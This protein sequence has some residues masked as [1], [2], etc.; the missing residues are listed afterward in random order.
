MDS[1]KPNDTV[2]E[3]SAADSSASADHPVGDVPANSNLK[4]YVVHTHSG[5]ENRAKSSLEEKIRR[6]GLQEMFGEILVPS[7]DVVELN[8]NGQRRSVKRKFFPG[9]M[10]VQMELNERTWHIVRSTPKISGFVGG[11]TEPPSIP[12]RE[13]QRLTK[14]IDEG[15]LK[16]Q[17][18]IQFVD[19]DNVRVVDGPFANFNGVIEAVNPDKGKARVLVSIFGRSTPL[20]LDFIQIERT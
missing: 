13:V 15:T 6:A 18:S 12:E 4:W 20:E 9:Y 1:E 16:A 17:P 2:I 3:E 8:K 7:E 14:E 11:T 10:L 19:G 5:S